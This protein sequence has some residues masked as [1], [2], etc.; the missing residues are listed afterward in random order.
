MEEHNLNL[1]NNSEKNN[2]EENITSELFYNEYKWKSI[3][4]NIHIKNLE[5]LKILKIFISIYYL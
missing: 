2:K 3:K 1:N 5:K 4:D